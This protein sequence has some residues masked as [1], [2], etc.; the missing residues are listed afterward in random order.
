MYHLTEFNKHA[1]LQEKYG[2][3][4][5]MLWVLGLYLD[6]PDLDA[7]AG[8]SLT[9]GGN[10]KCLDFLEVDKTGQKIVVAQ[11]YFSHKPGDKA[12]S[13]KAS[14]LTIAASWL[15]NGDKNAK[16]I[17]ERVRLRS[18]ECRAAL[19][20]E[21]IEQIELLYVHNRPESLNTQ[22]ELD[23]CSKT[24]QKLFEKYEIPVTC[25]EIGLRE[26]EALYR[27]RSSH[28]LVRDDI[29]VEGKHLGSHSTEDW[30]AHIYT[31]KGNWLRL[32][33]RQYDDRLFSANYRGFLGISKRKKINSAIKNTAER[34][35]TDFWV[36]NNGITLLANEVVRRG[37]K[38]T[39]KGISIINGAQTTG[40]LGSVDQLV[41]LSDVSV[42]CRVVVC[43]NP[44]KI[45][46]IVKY[47]NTQNRITT[48][49]QYANDET[50]SVIRAQF[51]EIGYEYSMKRGFDSVDAAIGIEKAAQPILSFNGH[52]V[53]AN[54]S[55]NSIFDRP[56]IYKRAFADRGAAH[57]LLAYCFS[58]SID[59]VKRSLEG[60]HE[61]TEN[62]IKQISLFNYL[63]FRHF[64]L[65]CI[66][67]CLQQFVG[68]NFSPSNAKLAKDE[69]SGSV[70]EVASKLEKITRQVLRAVSRGLENK[71]RSEN[72]PIS[73][74]MKSE[75]TLIEMKGELNSYLES[76]L[77]GQLDPEHKKLIY[78][79]N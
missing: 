62:E 29:T 51:A 23:T 36:Y 52:Y 59:D 74:L 32:L 77:D 75:S 73:R 61:K 48:W 49:D 28:I 79:E 5:Y 55:K 71:T 39:L 43:K 67:V 33:F 64:L 10:D 60:K 78:V 68:G 58:R 18:Q 25:R 45:D 27:E 42:M 35:P 41:G 40:S 24:A 9:D 20:A 22:E 34:Q 54:R 66:G 57:I 15:A 38:T 76:V 17:N 44:E 1:V 2:S 53:D 70:D 7:L 14:D 6:E 30:D 11:G 31:V 8:R 4:A 72:I 47:N 69:I 13:K 16:T 50:Q 65:A 46:D 56:E 3:N 37:R 12:P 19:E 26:I 63:S 21:E